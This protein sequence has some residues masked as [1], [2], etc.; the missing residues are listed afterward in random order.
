MS[1]ALFL[2]LILYIDNQK[3]KMG[4]DLMFE[5]FLQH[6]KMYCIHIDNSK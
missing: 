4:F 3:L 5:S 1:N 2:K 6:R